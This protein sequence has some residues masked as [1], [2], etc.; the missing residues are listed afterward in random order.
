MGAKQNRKCR[1]DWQSMRQGKALRNL[2]LHWNRGSFFKGAW[3]MHSQRLGSLFCSE[4]KQM[5]I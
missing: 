2:H 4:W 5:K 1:R 3:A